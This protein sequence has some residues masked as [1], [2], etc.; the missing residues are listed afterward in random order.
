MIESLPDR[1]AQLFGRAAHI[2]QLL[3]RVSK[4]GLTAVVARPL[5]GKT[6]TLT[7][8]AR[9]WSEQGDLVGY[10]ESKWAESS[11]LL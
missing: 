7:E 4:P 6:W 2:R 1:S 5:M 8:V 9:Q 3:D 11:H 10:H